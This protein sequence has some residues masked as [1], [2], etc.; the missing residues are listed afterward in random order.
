MIF[1][2]Q[3]L[4]AY[5]QIL[6]DDDFDKLRRQLKT[7]VNKVDQLVLEKQ[8]LDRMLKKKSNYTIVS[9]YNYWP[10]CLLVLKVFNYSGTSDNIT[11]RDG[12]QYT[13]ID[14]STKD[15]G[16]GPKNCFPMLLI[17]FE[18][19]IEYNLLYTK[20]IIAEFLLSPM[21]PLIR[22]STVVVY[23]TIAMIC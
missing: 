22:G 16:R 3:A 2:F 14:L 12:T 6:V 1:L 5:V 7:T 9:C 4:Q 11:L 18:P 17:H 15:T 8:S 10:P 21:C 19:P 23:Y 20:D 13:M